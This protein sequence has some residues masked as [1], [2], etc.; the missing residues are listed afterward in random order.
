MDDGDNNLGNTNFE[1]DILEVRTHLA[2]KVF[3]ATAVFTYGCWIR[4]I[5]AWRCRWCTLQSTGSVTRRSYQ[6]RRT[7][8]HNL[9]TP[10]SPRLTA[11]HVSGSATGIGDVAGRIKVQLAQG[12]RS[13]FGILGEV[14][15]PTGKEQ[16]LLGLGEYSARGVGHLVGSVRELRP[17]RQRGVPLPGGNSTNDSF[18]ATLGFD[19]L[20]GPWPHSPLM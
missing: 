4:W 2:V 20:L 19:Q 15:F 12:A 3:A 5:S 11:A 16:D 9:G 6:P 8:P 1:N 10:A 17:A 18:L 14:R 13:G 7:P